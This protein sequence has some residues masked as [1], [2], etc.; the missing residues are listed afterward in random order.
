MFSTFSPGLLPILHFD[1]AYSPC[2]EVAS[3]TKTDRE[4]RIIT[5]V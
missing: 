2:T 5:Y 3:Q 1:R 4:A